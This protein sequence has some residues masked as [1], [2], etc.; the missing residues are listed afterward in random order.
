MK[1]TDISLQARDKNRVNVSVD[2]KYRFSLDVFQ[3]G[4][5]GIKIGSE[6]TEEEISKLE[7]DSQFGKLYARSI[8][9]CLMRPRAIKEVR[10]YLRRKTLATRRRS[11]KTGKIIERPGVKPEITERVLGRLIEK[12]YLDDEKFAR[13][14]FEQRFMK[15]G[16]SIRRLKLELVQKGI[17]NTTIESLVK[18][19]IRSDDEELRKVIAKK[20]YRY[21]DQQKFMQYLARQGFSYDDIKKAL[22]NP[23]D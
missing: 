3:I 14:W 2:G 21:S 18:E 20:R 8:E 9:Y 12:K 13:F 22:E 16:A 10:D 5:L 1:I 4:E 15:K 17:D 19:N 23:K 7:D 6:Y 11:A